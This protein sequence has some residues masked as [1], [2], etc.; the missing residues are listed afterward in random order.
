MVESTKYG[1]AA[2]TPKQGQILVRWAR[3]Q[4]E[5]HL[6][7]VP[8]RLVTD[9]ELDLPEFRQVLGVFVTLHKRNA[10]R[11]CI[12]S[13]TG[14]EPIVDGVRRQALNAAFYDS[15]FSPVTAA[16]LDALHMEVSV[17][18][19]P[20]PLPYE[21]A[22]QLLQLLRPDVDG[23]ILEGPGGTRATFLPQVW[24]QLPTPEQF[25]AHL[26]RKAG[27]EEGA[28]RSGRLHISTYQVQSFEQPNS[29]EQ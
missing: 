11:G 19:T 9:E 3:Q 17:L 26:C 16:E 1:Q 27:L 13:L 28:W 20:Q 25:L 14:A 24:K 2:L 10:L 15:R 6:G 21:N 23:I 7:V 18:T 22:G 4:I 5:Q 12:G 29:G 8:S